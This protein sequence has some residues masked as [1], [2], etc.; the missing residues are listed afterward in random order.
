MVKCLPCMHKSGFD[1]QNFTHRGD[2]PVILALRR[3]RQD[4]QKLKVILD[5]IA[6]LK[7]F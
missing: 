6:R 5:F 2:N 7:P 3:Y 4:N 1:P